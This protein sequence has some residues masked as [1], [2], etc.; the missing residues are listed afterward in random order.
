MARGANIAV[1]AEGPFDIVQLSSM[2]IAREHIVSI[3]SGFR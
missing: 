3:V 2:T 1:H